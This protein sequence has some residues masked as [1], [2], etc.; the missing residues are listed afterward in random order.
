MVL[1]YKRITANKRAGGID[2]VSVDEIKEYVN[3]SWKDIRKQIQ[4]RRYKPLSV[5]RIEIPKSNGGIRNLG[6][7]NSDG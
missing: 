4:E 5:K 2:N 7:P 1:A 6:I 3:T